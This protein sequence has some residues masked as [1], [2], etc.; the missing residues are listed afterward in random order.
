[1]KSKS[2][3]VVQ[4]A[5]KTK[6][7]VAAEDPL[8]L[9]GVPGLGAAGI[10]C[11]ADEGITTTFQLIHK[12]PTYLKDVAG[13]DRDKAGEAFAY[14]KEKLR[15]AGLMQPAT[16]TATELLQ[17]RKTVKRISTTCKG[18]DNLLDGGI[19]CGACTEVFG[20]NGAGKTELGHLLAINVQLPIEDGGLAEPGKAPPLVQYIATENTF[21]PERII[22]MLAG[23]KLITDYPA[24]LKHKITDKKVL[25]IEEIKLKEEIEAQQYKESEKYLN[26]IIVNRVSDAVAQCT[27]IKNLIQ[28]VQHVPI[29]LIVIDSG[30]ALF[31][32]S[33]LG[34][35]NIKTKFDLMNEMVADLLAISELNGIA[36]VFINQI[37]N[38]PEEQYGQDPDIPY[39]GNIIGHAFPYI[40]KLEKSGQKY[41]MRIVK[42]PYQANDDVRYDLVQAGYVDVEK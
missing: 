9:E 14:M 6:K 11:L 4:T 18:T 19:E 10:K 22:S 36:I 38:A 42:S 7:E 21:R 13:M 24:A 37:Y 12:N 34:R 26:N 31:R 27:L 25:T 17:Q 32:S 5:T 8:S 3:E 35:G 2:K 39:G 15:A 30:T 16:M 28:T 1:M 41:R 23:K 20:E 33:Y 29:K 40:I